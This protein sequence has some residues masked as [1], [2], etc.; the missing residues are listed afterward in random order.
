MMQGDEEEHAVLLVNY[1]LWL[2][3]DA[4]LLLGREPLF[5]YNHIDAY[6][7]F[8]ACFSRRVRYTGRTDRL[9]FDTRK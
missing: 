9:C 3:K 4:F 5:N 1:F 8:G 2:G 6:G 7:K